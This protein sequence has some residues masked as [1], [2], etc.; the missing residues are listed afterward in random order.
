MASIPHDKHQPILLGRVKKRLLAEFVICC[1]IYCSIFEYRRAPSP[2]VSDILLC[3]MVVI[4]GFGFF[5]LQVDR[6]KN[7][8]YVVNYLC[9]PK[10]YIKKK[11]E[12]YK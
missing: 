7:F 12:K 6:I 1:A 11:E 8:T 10:K 3:D 5:P 9:A 4:E 2:G